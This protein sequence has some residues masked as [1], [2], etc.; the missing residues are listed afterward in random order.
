VAKSSFRVFTET[1]QARGQVKAIRA[2]GCA[3]Y[4][5]RQLDE[6]TEVVKGSGAKGLAWIAI[7]EGQVRSPIAKFL[8]ESEMEGIIDR[9]GAQ[10]GDLI[11]MVA[12]TPKVVAE[13]LGLLR[14]EMARQLSLIDNDVLG[15]AW[16]IDFPLLEWSEEEGRYFTSPIEADLDLLETHPGQV[17]ANAYD[18]V[19]NG[20]EIGGGSI[21]IYQ[22]P[23][24]ETMFRALGISDEQAQA[25][26]G[27]LLQ[28]FEYGAPPHGGIAPGIDRLVMLLAGEPNIREVMAFPKTQSA[29]DLMLQAPS[30]I[31][32]KQLKELHIAL[33]L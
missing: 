2:Q 9:M 8:T 31:S 18:I 11:L 21:R 7:R 28:A 24:Q 5:R 32:E 1:V 30:P 25:Q 16:V 22:R 6:L 19:A 13:S 4:T 23:L 10:T 26:F 29:L 20:Y 3:D 15:F 14:L 17:H 12:D 27:H 33:D